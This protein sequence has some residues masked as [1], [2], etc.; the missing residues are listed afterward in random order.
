MATAEEHYQLGKEFF[1]KNKTNPQQS[2]NLLWITV[3]DTDQLKQM[4]FCQSSANSKE[5]KKEK[6]FI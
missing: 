3:Y 1:S 6:Y 4:D 5:Q 2:S